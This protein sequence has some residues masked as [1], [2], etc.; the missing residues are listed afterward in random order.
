MMSVNSAKVRLE[1]VDR[2]SIPESREGLPWGM[3]EG[4]PVGWGM[5]EGLPVGRGMLG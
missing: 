2:V 3:E 5:E 1:P 4:L